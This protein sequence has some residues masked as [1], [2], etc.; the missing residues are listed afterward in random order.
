MSA[1]HGYTLNRAALLA[2]AEKVT[3]CD[4]FRAEAG[5]SHFVC[6]DCGGT[7]SAHIVV[8][9]RQ[10][11]GTC[12]HSNPDDAAWPGATFCTKPGSPWNGKLL[13]LVGRCEAWEA[14]S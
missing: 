9:L 13:P 4:V 3:A 7:I 8:A 10:T 14:Q 12:A 11:C 5:G 1:S 6:A 2:D